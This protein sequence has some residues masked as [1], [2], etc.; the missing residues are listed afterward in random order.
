MARIV[1]TG[2]SGFVGSHLSLMLAEEN[3]VA[4]FGRRPLPSHLTGKVEFIK[5]DIRDFQAVEKAME[6]AE[7]VYHLA[8]QVGVSCSFSDPYNNFLINAVGSINVVEACARNN[9][10]NLVIFSSSAVYG[11]NPDVPLKE[12]ADTLPLSPYGMNKDI[13]DK[14]ISHIRKNVSII[15]PFDIYG[16]AHDRSCIHHDAISTFIYNAGKGRDLIVFG[17]GNQTRDFVHVSDVCRAAVMVCGKPGVFNVGTGR[18]TTLTGLVELINKFSGGKSKI[19]Y[20][21]ERSG[22]IKHSYA[23][24]TKL[25]AIG[26]TPEISLEKGL[27]E[28]VKTFAKNR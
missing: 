19:V 6:C 24:V 15:R 2:G 20:S 16:P 9:V 11:D 25:K 21:E 1:I 13:V 10:K 5:G 18:P 3:D 22:D 4:V 28:L 23:D 26:W 14:Y 7:T 27:K 12:D 8:A 17:D